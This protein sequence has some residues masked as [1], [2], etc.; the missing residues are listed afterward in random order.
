MATNPNS[1]RP[2]RLCRTC[3]SSFRPNR[4]SHNFC[5]P[6]CRKTAHRLRRQAAAPEA[7]DHLLA[8]LHALQDAAGAPHS[9]RHPYLQRLAEIRCVE[10]QAQRL[11]MRLAQLRG[12]MAKLSEPRLRVRIYHLAS[13]D[14]ALEQLDPRC[15]WTGTYASEQGPAVLILGSEQ[16]A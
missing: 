16:D 11:Q 2:L 15:R 1:S 8:E 9:E 6:A 3:R 10:H 7:A 5:R 12:Q 4:A 14:S 13:A